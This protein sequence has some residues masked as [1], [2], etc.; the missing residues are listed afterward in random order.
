MR[1]AKLNETSKEVGIQGLSQRVWERTNARWRGS[2]LRWYDSDKRQT[3]SL[4]LPVVVVLVIVSIY[5]LAIG[6]LPN[7][8]MMIPTN[9]LRLVVFTL[10][11]LSTVTHAAPPG[12]PQ[13]GNGLWYSSPAK[14]WSRHYLPVGNGYLG[15]MTP[16]GTREEELQLNI[17]SMW[18]GGPFSD[19]VSLV[20][21][22][23]GTKS[24]S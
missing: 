22:V 9:L 18:S 6:F 23:I 1:H 2:V 10:V 15:A 4:G 20:L 12:F 5:V 24:V 14:I 16:G 8:S 7:L 17:E 3:S 19:R 13:S 11:P 21:L